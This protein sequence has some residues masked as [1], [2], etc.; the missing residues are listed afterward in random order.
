VEETR[1]DAAPSGPVGRIKAWFYEE[2]EPPAWPRHGLSPLNRLLSFVILFS[3]IA[4]VL[5]TEPTVVE[6]NERLFAIIEIVFVAIFIAEYLVRLWIAPMLPGLAGR[7]FPRLRYLVSWPALIDLAAILPVLL[8]VGGSHSLLMRL[9]RLIRLLRFAKLAR[10]SSA[11][12]Y[13]F[14]AIHARRFELVVSLC[15]GL[16]LL[17]FSS[18]LL[19]LVEGDVQPEHFGSIPRAMWWAVVT[20]TTVGYGD[21][22]PVTALGKLCAGAT[23]VAGISIIAMPTGILAA[24]FSDALQRRKHPSDGADA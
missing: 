12:N 24:A 2:L 17:V 4:A 16:L 14:E 3:C 13:L 15:V 11:L 7:R 22:V 9:L 5:E 20:L 23:A 6:G 21:A 10:F 19:Y 18:T 1:L 8:L